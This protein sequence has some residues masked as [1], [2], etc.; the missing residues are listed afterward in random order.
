MRL[1]AR[2]QQLDALL[3]LFQALWHPQPFRQA[4]PAWCERW[5]ALAAELLALDDA[6][7]SVLNADSQ[8]ALATLAGHVP[9]IAELMPLLDLPQRMPLPASDDDERW[10]WEIPGRKR[11]QIEAFA[12]AATST[13]A[14]P[15]LDWC[16]GKGHL[17][18]LLAEQWQVPVRTLE[19]D[20]ALCRTGERLAQRRGV[21]QEF[22]V[23]DAL[24]TGLPIAAGQHVV[25]LH[26]CGELHR[27][28]I[29]LGAEQGVA[30]FSVAP[31]CYH[32]HLDAAYRPLAS[33]S[34]LPLTPEDVRLA[35]TETVTAG[36]RERRQ[37]DRAM[38]CKLGFAAW[39]QQLS[40]DAYRSF[41]PVPEAWMRGSF[42]EFIARMCRREGLEPPLGGDLEHFERRGVERQREVIR[43]S[44]VR[45]AFRRALE[46]WL[47]GDLAVSLEERGYVA[48]LGVFCARELTP[49]N[50]LISARRG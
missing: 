7:A 15:V 37:R 5:P 13:E 23:A 48:E 38:A 28:L 47:A 35:V 30:R 21:P 16:G 8:A 49:R 40:G 34:S 18:R 11:A 1:R 44:I 26:A 32:L 45:H 25:A 3:P 20:A 42:A 17:G 6:A 27:R 22:V 36:A 29:C 43:L 4:R 33:V 2:Q 31:C 41:K 12:A 19:I 39:Q 9:E 50:L 10:A 14:L 46:V 24:T